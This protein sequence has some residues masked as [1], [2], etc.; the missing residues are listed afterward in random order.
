MLWYL[1]SYHCHKTSI[2]TGETVCRFGNQTGKSETFCLKLS[3]FP[4]FHVE[5]LHDLIFVYVVCSA[6]S[7]K[8][9]KH[10]YTRFSVILTHDVSMNEE[11]FFPVEFMEWDSIY[12]YKH[13]ISVQMIHLR[14]KG[15]KTW[16]KRWRCCPEQM[17]LNRK[18]FSLGML[19]E[20]TK[21]HPLSVLS[22]KFTLLLSHQDLSPALFGCYP[23]NPR[24]PLLT[25]RQFIDLLSIF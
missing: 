8:M 5:Y 24:L 18:A 7:I 9:H 19:I 6:S 11:N 4:C 16:E 21:I 13:E 1:T 10:T 23:L 3:K 20:A 15:M 12:L 25:A 2:T 22:K 17:Y 14:T